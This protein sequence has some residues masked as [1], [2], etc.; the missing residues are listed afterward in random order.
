MVK[1]PPLPVTTGEC[2]LVRTTTPGSG[3]ANST[4]FPWATTVPFTV[5]VGVGVGP[6]PL[7]PLLQPIEAS[8]P[9]VAMDRARRRRRMAGCYP[10]AGLSR[11]D[12]PV[13]TPGPDGAVV[14][15]Y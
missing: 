3:R 10:S 8:A 12:S 2:P 11:A 15:G 14:G 6:P 1:R 13:R 4:L 5:T 7:P 9:R